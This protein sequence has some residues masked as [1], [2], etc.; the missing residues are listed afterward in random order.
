MLEY[1]YFLSI[2]DMIDPN[3]PSSLFNE[4]LWGDYPL[5]RLGI[6]RVGTTFFVGIS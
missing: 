1:S 6:L 2:S 4:E 3:S 5:L